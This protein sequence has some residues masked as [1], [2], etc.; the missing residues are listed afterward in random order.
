MLLLDL[1][2]S[3][4]TLA[5]ELLPLPTYAALRAYL[6]SV[7][8]SGDRARLLITTLNAF[9]VFIAQEDTDVMSDQWRT[10]PDEVQRQFEHFLRT[11]LSIAD[12]TITK[13]LEQLRQLRQLML[14]L[15]ESSTL[16]AGFG[17]AM[18]VLLA[19]R[20]LSV[21]AA[22]RAV[23]ISPSVLRGWMLG[24]APTATMSV[25]L[26]ALEAFLQIPAGTLRRRLP[27]RSRM[28]PERSLQARGAFGE[29]MATYHARRR[30][31]DWE[32]LWLSY[33]KVRH[34]WE[35]YLVWKCDRNRLEI[36]I[37]LDRYF[38]PYWRTKPAPEVGCKVRPWMQLPDGRVATSAGVSYGHLATYW[39]WLRTT[40]GVAA[41]DCVRLSWLLDLQKVRAHLQWKEQRS[42]CRSAGIRD[43]VV[44][45]AALTRPGAGYLW[46][47]PGLLA[48]HPEPL[49]LAGYDLR[50][51]DADEHQRRWR[52]LCTHV[53]EQ[54]NELKRK[55]YAPRSLRKVRNTSQDIRSL[56]ELDD[57]LAALVRALNRLRREAA[58]LAPGRDRWTMLRDVLLCQ[59]MLSN[60][61]RPAQFAAMTYRRDGGGN[62]YQTSRGAWRLQFDASAFKNERGAA[63][64]DYSVGVPR[65]LWSHIEH[66]LRVVRPQLAGAETDYVF[67]PADLSQRS[68]MR[69]L[70]AGMWNGENLSAR[71]GKVGRELFPQMR[72]F[73]AYTL[74]HLV[75]TAFLKKHPEQ[76][77]QLAK[78]LND[79]LATVLRVYARETHD[80]AFD[81]QNR[82]IDDAMRTA[83][84]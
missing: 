79:K 34:V 20:A 25:R 65:S 5:P 15:H 45:L 22:A 49:A 4:E 60:P 67:L 68:A 16:P 81:V 11:K 26:E 63:S 7:F 48:A 13:R 74:R 37:P 21:S 43:F 28:R 33:D 82:D 55:Q 18:R 66:Y 57:P 40:Q 44:Q 3:D 69:E 42:G 50:A 72:A 24:A 46:C 38:S 64:Q 76:F 77:T 54:A 35:P 58:L 31:P 84:E 36:D 47:K 80:D 70:K 6:H 51:V 30:E 19:R 8:P 17:D 61:L 29:R 9:R 1:P 83:E 10:L 14:T 39:G 27:R 12:S 32:P 41:Q 52:E 75:A 53:H 2:L 56:A 59:L 23:G 78:L 71:I 62:L 73:S